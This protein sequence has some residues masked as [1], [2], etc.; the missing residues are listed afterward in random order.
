[1]LKEERMAQTVTEPRYTAYELEEP[2]LTG[3]DDS[4]NMQIAQTER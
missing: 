1:M 2:K 3:E 4:I